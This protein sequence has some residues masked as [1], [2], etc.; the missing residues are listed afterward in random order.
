MTD[1]EI[2]HKRKE[3]KEKIKSLDARIKP[4]EDALNVVLDEK[5]KMFDSC[6]HE[7]ICDDCK[8]QICTCKSEWGSGG[9]ECGICGVYVMGWYC[10]KSPDHLCY[11]NTEE[12]SNG[13]RYVELRDGNRVY[14]EKGYS[15]ED[16]TDDDCL[17]CHHPDERK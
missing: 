3:F 16:E 13:N 6:K 14:M 5:K 9:A 17:F 15:N 10:A 4:L 2:K 7:V 11:Y 1:E 8:K 12:D